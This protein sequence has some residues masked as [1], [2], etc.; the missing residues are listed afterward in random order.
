MVRHTFA[1][2]HTFCQWIFGSL[3]QLFHNWRS[4]GIEGASKVCF[5]LGCIFHGY[6]GCSW[7]SFC[8]VGN[9][10]VPIYPHFQCDF[11]LLWGFQWFLRGSNSLWNLQLPPLSLLLSCFS[12]NLGNLVH[13]CVDLK[14]WRATWGQCHLNYNFLLKFVLLFGHDL[15]LFGRGS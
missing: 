13:F 4:S 9:L 6:F 5:G 11:G 15:Y 8:K 2:Y 12:S 10:K 7:C 14:M 3:G 1:I